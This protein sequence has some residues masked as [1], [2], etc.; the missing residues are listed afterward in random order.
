MRKTHRGARCNLMGDTVPGKLRPGDRIAGHALLTASGKLAAVPDAGRV[1]HLQFRRFAGCPICNLHLRSFVRRRAEIEAANINEV[2][3]FHSTADEL[4]QYE[5]DLPFAVIGDPDKRLYREFGVEAAPK[6]LTDARAMLAILRTLLPVTVETI[7]TGKLAANLDP[8]GGRLGLPADFLIAPDG[9]VLACK[10]GEHA[11]D[12]W[13]VDEL[14]A[15]AG[16][17]V[18]GN[19]AA[20]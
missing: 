14:L 3:V 10:Y 4:R 17:N 9:R 18:L 11:D 1:I 12:Q 19:V 6:A 16:A 20:G 13:S 7:R 5:A 8:H 15:L 2:V